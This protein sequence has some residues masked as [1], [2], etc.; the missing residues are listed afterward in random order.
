MKPIAYQQNVRGW[1]LAIEICK[2]SVVNFFSFFSYDRRWYFWWSKS[3]TDAGVT[4]KLNKWYAP[5]SSVCIQCI[6]LC[7][8]WLVFND[9]SNNLLKTRWEEF[10]VFFSAFL[11]VGK[12]RRWTWF[13]LAVQVTLLSYVYHVSTTIYVHLSSI[14]WSGSSIVAS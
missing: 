13:A 11:K 14:S 1:G 2:N 7:I 12:V 6:H 10:S 5:S 8:L 3:N 4:I 9:E